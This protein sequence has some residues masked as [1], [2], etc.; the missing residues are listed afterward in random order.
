MALPYLACRRSAGEACRWSFPFMR[1][2]FMSVVGQTSDET[3]R[4]N[5]HGLM[6]AVLGSPTTWHRRQERE[7]PVR[8]CPETSISSHALF[9]WSRS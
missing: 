7:V 3:V 5:V 8:F 9:R 1:L 4:V 2:E 6:V